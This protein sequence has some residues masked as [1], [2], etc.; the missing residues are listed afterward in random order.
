MTGNVDDAYLVPFAFVAVEEVDIMLQIFLRQDVA[1]GGFAF[2]IFLQHAQDGLCV[3]AETVLFLVVVKQPFA[4]KAK[5]VLHFCF[6]YLSPFSMRAQLL[7]VVVP[8]KM[9]AMIAGN[10][11]DIASKD[12]LTQFAWIASA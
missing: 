5:N 4:L 10:E 3:Q 2:I 6:I 7:K 9:S 11:V 12:M 1:I 8:I